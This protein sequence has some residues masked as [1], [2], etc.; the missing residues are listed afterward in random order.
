MTRQDMA[1]R[2]GMNVKDIRPTRTVRGEKPS[3]A[4]AWA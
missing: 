3:V 1:Q 2:G 4:Y